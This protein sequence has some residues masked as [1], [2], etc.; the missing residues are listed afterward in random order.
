VQNTGNTLVPESFRDLQLA[1]HMVRAVALLL[2]LPLAQAVSPVQKVVEL[3]G[4]CKAKVQNDLDAE[5]KAMNE[6]TAFCDDE[7]KD[8]AYAVETA[9]RT[10]ND[11]SAAAENARA[12]IA[13]LTDEISTLGS[14][15]AGKDGEL[16]QATSVRN[17]Q[18]SDFVAAEKELVQSVDEL[19][20]AASVL[21]KGMSFAQGSSQQKKVS[22]AITALSNI[23]DAE[24]LDVRSRRSLKSFLQATAQAK[25]SEDDDLS[26]S[27]PQAKQVAYESS[28]GGIVKTV[29]EMQ[30]KAED[31]L[32]ALR[33]K[34]MSD[35]HSFAMVESGLND[36]IKHANQ[37]LGSAKSSK[38][39]NEEKQA[40]A[41]GKLGETQ[42]SKAADESYSATLKSECDQKAD[43][44][45]E[46]Q[47]SAK[48]EMGAIDKASEILVSGVKAF[49]QT[50]AKT[51]RWSP[52]D[53]DEDDKTAA[54]REKVVAVLKQLSHDHR[55]YAMAQMASMA[56]SDPFVK[57]R[58]LIEDMVSK[59][60][61]EANEDATHE[62]FCNEEMGKSTKS[63]EE[64]TMKVENYASRMD[65]A[66]ATIAELGEAV[67]TL[68]AEV[69]QIDKSQAEATSLRATEHADYAKSSK[70]FRDSAQ[71]V[72]RAIEVLK[73]YY[74]GASLVQV[75]SKTRQPD[76]GGQKS[77][78]ASTIIS[79]LEM[80]EEDFTTL[81]AESEATEDAAAKAF[82]KLSDENKVS[83]AA[84]LAEAKG[85]ES[86]S[87]SLTTQLEH[88]KEDHASVSKELDAVLSYL[89]KLKPECESKAMSY[90]ERKA[91]RD[92]E[93]AGLKD[94]LNILA[95]DSLAL[96][97]T[98]RS[99]R[100][101]RKI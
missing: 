16:A 77:D 18:H 6:Y 72:A 47:K 68:E 27:Q 4:E 66:S 8:K 54:A 21:K 49:V 88:H 69:A 29:E 2:L 82:T 38:S 97:Q 24:W 26:L 39:S 63:K 61:K 48:D 73:N 35:T 36:E 96:A 62:A 101:A 5:A 99:L 74:Q 100:V 67:K 44:W 83:K 19:G 53:N 34:D 56:A 14:S 11:L 3:L 7:L 65:Q 17:A 32:S 22:A 52:D 12:Q 40:S 92:N 91:A 90:E 75:S 87:K 57:I 84:K 55:S 79:V 95:G 43:D 76:F 78:T 1:R 15:I 98:G 9:G 41:T 25:E 37:K 59:L 81:L 33:K 71:A 80:S 28:S 23:V 30:G 20:R 42:K 94:A 60:V 70:D 10:I 85:K 93:I 86:E 13:T 51:K 31:T 50:A 64:K 46:R 89:D 58:G 45:S